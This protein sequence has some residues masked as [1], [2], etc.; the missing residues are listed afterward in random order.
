MKNKNDPEEYNLLLMRSN[1]LAVL[2]AINTVS[3]TCF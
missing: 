2:V 1:V 3:S